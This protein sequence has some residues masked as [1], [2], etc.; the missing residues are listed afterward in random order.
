MI[1][2]QNVWIQFAIAALPGAMARM[3][4]H[5]MAI[6]SM[7]G[8]VPPKLI[9]ATCRLADA[10]T[11]AWDTQFGELAFILDGIQECYTCK[12]ALL[13]GMRYVASDG[14]DGEYKKYCNE[15]CRDEIKGAV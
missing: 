9:F 5:D 15:K 11:E 12:K 7:N 8:H 4:E 2:R 6:M 13:K 10:M 1:D 3:S 14:S